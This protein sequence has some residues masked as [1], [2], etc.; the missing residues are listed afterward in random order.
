MIYC[1]P[2]DENSVNLII[3]SY[4]FSKIVGFIDSILCHDEDPTLE[5]PI[6]IGTYPIRDDMEINNNDSYSKWDDELENNGKINWKLYSCFS[7]FNQLVTFFFSL[8]LK[9]QVTKKRWKYTVQQMI[10]SDP[11]IQCSKVQLRI[12]IETPLSP[13]YCSIE[14]IIYRETVYCVLNEWINR[15][16]N[17]LLFS[18]EILFDWCNYFR[19]RWFQT[20][21]YIIIRL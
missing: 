10:I 2:S 9:S 13:P 6:T 19:F 14:H 17:Y 15:K 1:D 7:F 3:C 16:I 20:A 21:H 18:F 4:H 8:S 5:F 11:S 12:P